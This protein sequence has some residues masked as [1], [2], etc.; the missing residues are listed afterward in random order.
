MKVN[1]LLESSNDDQA[2]IQDIKD[3][4]EKSLETIDLNFEDMDTFP[5]RGMDITSMYS[6]NDPEV[7]AKLKA[8]AAALRQLWLCI[9]HRGGDGGLVKIKRLYLDD[10]NTIKMDNRTY[11]ISGIAPIIKAVNITMKLSPSAKALANIP[12]WLQDYH[13][14]T[15]TLQKGIV[16]FY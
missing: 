9:F 13:G 10:P 14:I 16:Y 2:L 5:K 1:Q 8:K 3:I 7:I 4:L 12:D 11:T 6:G 15:D